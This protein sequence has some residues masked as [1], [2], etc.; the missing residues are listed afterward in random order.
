[1]SIL[2]N[3]VNFVRRLEKLLGPCAIDVELVKFD[4]QLMENPDIED[5]EYQQGTLYGYEIRAYLM[6]KFQHTCQYCCGKSED[7]V[8]E[9]EHMIPKSRGGS[10]SVKNATL[11][12]RRCNQKKGNRTPEEW[13]LELEQKDKPSALDTQR[14]NCLKNVISGKKNGTNL[15]YAAWA[16]SM[17]WRLYEELSVLSGEKIKVG[18]GS[19]TALNRHRLGIPKDHHLDALCCVDVPEHGYRDAVQPCLIVK[20][21]GRGSRLIGQINECGIIIVKYKDHH[22]RV[23]GLQTGDI[24]YAAVPNG[25][26]KG[27]YTGRIM[28]RSSGSHDIRTI[29]GKRF[30]MPKNT[31]IRVLQHTDGYQYSFEQAIPLG[32]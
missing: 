6:E 8:L 29:N 28:V 18:T 5:I 25:K 22:K 10:D 3:I 2:N 24:V 32:N 7:P 30:S 1:M 23:N 31:K 11:A 27:A 21:M 14:I 12:C 16:N 20:A 4:P 9:W 26:Y 17:R 15:R 13:L 19:K